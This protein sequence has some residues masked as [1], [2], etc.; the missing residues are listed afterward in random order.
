MALRDDVA[1]AIYESSRNFLPDWAE[2]PEADQ[3]IRNEFYVNADA[4]IGVC[5]GYLRDR[6]GWGGLP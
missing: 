4:A 6:D 3:V 5:D 1:E 2:W